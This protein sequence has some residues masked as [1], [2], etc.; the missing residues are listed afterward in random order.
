MSITPGRKTVLQLGIGEKVLARQSWTLQ[1]G[2]SHIV[3]QRSA[4][5]LV[6]RNVFSTGGDAWILRPQFH[7]TIQALKT[8]VGGYISPEEVETAPGVTSMFTFNR[9]DDLPNLGA[10]ADL[11]AQGAH[12]YQKRVNAA[13]D[14]N[15]ARLEA[16]ELA[17]PAPPADA[18]QSYPLDRLLSGL[19]TYPPNTPYAVQF[20]TPEGL[21]G[22]D[23]LLNFY[24]GGQTESKPDGT[25]GG[26]FCLTFRGDGTAQL[27]ER[28]D[29]ANDWGVGPVEEFRWNTP[30]E[31][32]GGILS[33]LG[34]IPYAEGRTWFAGPYAAPYSTGGFSHLLG[35]LVGLMA[36]A[37]QR[38]PG[39]GT[40]SLYRESKSL[41]GHL[42]TTYMT[43]SG[44]V[45]LD[46]RRPSRIPFAIIRGNYPE[47]GVLIDSPFEINRYLP[48]DTPI[49]VAAT[50]YLYDNTTIQAALY[51][52]TTGLPL[53]TDPDGAFLSVA[54]SRKYFAVFTLVSADGIGTPALYAYSV[55]VQGGFAVRAAT[56][57][58]TARIQDCRII[59]PDAGVT[60]RSGRVPDRC[61]L[62]RGGFGVVGAHGLFSRASASRRA[63]MLASTSS[64][65]SVSLSTGSTA[66]GVAACCPTFTVCALGASTVGCCDCFGSRAR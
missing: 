14:W 37:L 12:Y 58:V 7:E 8:S 24:W 63:S 10:D 30:G 1:R 3:P 2:A 33:T 51:D 22:A 11:P 34:I 45:R 36:A 42:H 46:L 16:D 31:S 28:D 50:S 13:A 4:A 44:V 18:T 38:Q 5:G 23:G 48:A 15:E 66:G 43:G 55:D 27:W 35:P 54:G 21:G 47:S 29:T 40:A 26:E 6:S 57:L 53:A 41:T 59:G 20:K 52:A 9:R 32:P 60:C 39:A 61:R 62:D 56:P 25:S 19:V 49:R 17:Y 65:G 64:V